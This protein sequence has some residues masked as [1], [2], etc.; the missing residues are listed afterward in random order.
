MSAR[1]G[2]DT[3]YGEQRSAAAEIGGGGVEDWIGC[4]RAMA[5]ELW[6]SSRLIENI[7]PLASIISRPGGRGSSSAR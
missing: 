7:R 6:A 1:R 2:R 4:Q 3:S 5:H